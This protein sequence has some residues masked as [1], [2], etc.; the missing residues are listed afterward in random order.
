MMWGAWRRPLVLVITSKEPLARLPP[1]A[2]F[3]F[4]YGARTNYR[5]VIAT[6]LGLV[7]GAPAGGDTLR[8]RV[9]CIGH[10]ETDTRIHRS[11]DNICEKKRSAGDLQPE[12]RLGLPAAPLVKLD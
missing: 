7:G 4:C 10:S 1:I 8:R 12:I 3:S 11:S 5:G 9:G 2:A 6:V